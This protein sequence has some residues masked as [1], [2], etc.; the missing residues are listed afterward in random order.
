MNINKFFGCLLVYEFNVFNE[1]ENTVW[2]SPPL[3]RDKFI[4]SIFFVLSYLLKP[5]YKKTHPWLYE[6]IVKLSQKREFTKPTLK[7]PKKKNLK[8]SSSSSR[9]KNSTATNMINT[10]SNS[11]RLNSIEECNQESLEH[12]WQNNR[13]LE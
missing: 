6:E 8:S 2:I 5:F 9:R 7:P 12:A 4:T 3:G 10:R 1:H 13:R 11:H